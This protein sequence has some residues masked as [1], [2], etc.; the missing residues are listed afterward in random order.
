MKYV[1]KSAT[2]GDV[3]KAQLGEDRF[4]SR[5]EALSHARSL[6]AAGTYVYDVYKRGSKWVVG[7]DK[8]KPSSLGIN[9]QYK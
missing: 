9:S 7:Y 5:E 8:D 4:S 6:T 1:G 2:D 3:H